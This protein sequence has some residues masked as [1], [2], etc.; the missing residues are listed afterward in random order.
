VSA[1]ADR[2][3]IERELGSGGM[4][5]V[6][7]A[8]DLKH[9]RRVAVKVLRPELAAVLGGERFLKEIEVTASLQHPSILALYDSGEADSFLYY[10]M[11]YIEGESLREKLNREKQLSIE[12]TIAITKSV[13]AALQY[14]HE[15]A[16]IHRDIKPE[17]IL[18]HSGQALVADFGIALA[19]THAGGTRLTETGLSLGTPE[20]MS[21]EQAAGDR[22]L[23]ARSDV[24]SL[25]CVVYEM[26]VGDA[27]HTGS[28]VQAIVAKVLSEQPTPIERSRPTVPV[29]VRAAVWRALAKTPADRFPSPTQF[30]EALTNPAFR[31]PTGMDVVVSSSSAHWKQRL[32]LPLAAVAV[33]LGALALWG[34]LREAPAGAVSRFRLEL[35]S[36]VPLEAA[37]GTSIAVSPDG[38]RFVYV[39]DGPRLYVRSMDQL[40]ETL[41]PGTDG[42]YNPI[43]SPDGEWV[44][45]G[46][47]G[48]IKKVALAGGPPV[49][50]FETPGLVGGGSWGA[51]D[52]LL[53]PSPTGPGLVTIPASG[54]TPRIV[55]AP[56]AE[57]GESYLTPD[58]LPGEVF[59]RGD[60]SMHAAPFDL[61]RVAVTGSAMP[62]VENVRLKGGMVAEYAVSPSGTLVYMP[63]TGGVRN[64]VLVDRTGLSRPLTD[65]AR[66]FYGPRFS[67]DGRRVAVTVFEGGTRDVW[68]YDI[69][70]S[71]SARAEAARSISS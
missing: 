29:N 10:V 23:D 51:D 53:F 69:Q 7:L 65:V 63:A 34:W 56:D 39:G 59:V 40:T 14:A 9:H 25:G 57:S 49:T 45:F 58:L 38:S 28:T 20:Y 8:E 61:R 35:A 47:D 66:A 55:V 67:P 33:L 43:F 70:R 48:A 22:E 37:S 30:V 12:E 64:L 36:T 32:A 15:R 4:A 62:V 24:Y 71:P 54:G 52:R 50:I 2:Y 60:G 16:V 26:L 27:P 13:A 46:T 68:L 17:N 5:T 44:A 42:A 6:Y 19:V 18:L 11:P 41:I 31:L 21:P 1:L 3:R